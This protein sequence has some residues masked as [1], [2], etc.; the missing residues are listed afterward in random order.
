MKEKTKVS[1][2]FALLFLALYWLGVFLYGA[3]F[4]RGPNVCANY[5]MSVFSAIGI[6]VMTYLCPTWKD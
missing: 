3:P 6:F 2:A 5:F 1:F 4:V